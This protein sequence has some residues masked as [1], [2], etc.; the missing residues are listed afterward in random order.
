M[1]YALTH[2]K[3][4]RVEVNGE[5]LPMR[6][7][8]GERED[9]LT[10]AV[11]SRLAYLSS[12]LLDGLFQK[13]LPDSGFPF[14]ELEETEYWPIFS[15]GI[16]TRVEP[17]LLLRFDWGL[18][19][20]EVKRPHCGYQ[21]EQQWYNEL[22]CLPDEDK[23]QPVIF[24]ALGGNHLANQQMFN[25]LRERLPEL[26][27]TE[28]IQLYS[29]DWEMVG[30]V[31]ASFAE[32]V[33]QRHQYRIL[34]DVLEVLDLYRV[35]YQDVDLLEL[36]KLATGIDHRALNCWSITSVP[37]LQQLSHHCLKPIG[38][39]DGINQLCSP[40]ELQGTYK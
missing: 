30:R 31:V 17:D 27:F 9:M 14:S 22:E 18:L 26:G 7:L 36:S 37:T 39:L 1:L 33:E 19:V 29:S 11:F 6:A 20:V 5:S 2:N 13:L 28:D 16:Q 35:A 32:Q 4:G 15:S 38:K 40:S 24:W 10:A 21:E 12:D 34:R 25:T 23:Q 3:A 8:F